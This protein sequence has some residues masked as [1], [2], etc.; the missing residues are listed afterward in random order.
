MFSDIPTI[1]YLTINGLE[2]LK[3]PNNVKWQLEQLM[4]IEFHGDELDLDNCEIFLQSQQ[5]TLKKLVFENS[6]CLL[7]PYFIM[8]NLPNLKHLKI[9]LH[10]HEEFDDSFL[11]QNCKLK[12][13]DIIQF[14][15]NN[16]V[17]KALLNHYS[18]IKYFSLYSDPDDASVSLSLKFKLE[19]LTHLALLGLKSFSFLSSNVLN[20]KVLILSYSYGKDDYDFSQFPIENLKNIEKLSFD[21]RK[22]EEVLAVVQKCPKLT[23]LNLFSQEWYEDENSSFISDINEI[24]SVAPNVKCLGIIEYSLTKQHLTR[25]ELLTQILKKNL[26]LKLYSSY[27]SMLT[28]DEK[29]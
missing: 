28:Y 23:K 2:I 4:I 12:N 15:E 27:G 19:N 1:K 3:F 16:N 24:L 17:T 20:I 7:S 13:L 9:S 18:S 21:F 26:Y 29:V 8:R 22:V 10:N 25:Q 14:S 6:Y 11:L 5:S